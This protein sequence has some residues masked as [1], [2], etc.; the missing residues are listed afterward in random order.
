VGYRNDVRLKAGILLTVAFG[1]FLAFAASAAGPSGDAG[2][3]PTRDGGDA[4][5][6]GRI[7]KTAPDP[8]PAIVSRNQWIFDLR[9]DNGDIYL[10]GV[11]KLD[12][13]GPQATPRV[14]GRF[15]VELYEGPTL[16]ERA[17]FDFPMLLFAGAPGVP[18]GGRNAVS[19]D[20]RLISRIG[21]MFPVT[22]RG[23][24]LELWDRATDKRW[25]LPWPPTD[26]RAD[27]KQD[28]GAPPSR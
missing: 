12:L 22:S 11:H 15:A 5:S 16:I 28:A 9:Y 19:F 27:S 1:G 21:V 8:Q 6:G 3:S 4:A 23:T 13:S 24:R 10:L 17:R 7:S 2:S 25:P 14:I 20:K 18:D 26:T